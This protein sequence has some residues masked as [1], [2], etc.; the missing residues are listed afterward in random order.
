MTRRLRLPVLF[1]LL[2]LFVAS[3]APA[4]PEQGPTPVLRADFDLSEYRTVDRAITTTIQR[5]PVGSANAGQVPYVGIHFEA[6]PAN[7]LRVS[8]IDS[9]SPA[10][11]AGLQAGDIVKLV[12]GQR[13]TSVLTFREM[14]QAY[15]PGE[16]LILRVE[17]DGKAREI[18][19]TLAPLSAPLG[20]PSEGA[21]RRVRVGI[22]STPGDKG[23]RVDQVQ[24]GS[25]AEK[26]GLQPGDLIVKIDDR[27]AAGIERLTDVLADKRPGDKLKLQV[28]RDNKEVEKVVTLVAAEGGG[29][30]RGRRDWDDRRPGLFRKP[31][32]RLAVLPISYPDVKLNAKIPGAEWEKALFSTGAYTGKSVTGQTVYGS[33]NDYYRELSCGTFRVEGKVFEPLKAARKRSEYASANR[34]ALFGEV[35]D[36]LYEREGRNA[37]K[38]FDGIFFLYAGDRAPSQRGG[39]YWP[40]KANFSHKGERWNYFICPEGGERMASISV[41]SHE[42][43]HM[44]GMPDLYAAPDTPN[45]EGLGIWCTMS[46]GHGR[47]GKPLH[48]SAWCK[49][50]LGWLKPVIID[51][52]VPQKLLLAPVEGTSG[53]CYKVLIR[54]DGSEYLLLENRVAKGFDRD[55][56]G[57]GLL[58]WRVVDN[59]PILEESHGILGPDGPRRYLGSVPYPSRSNRAFTPATTPSSRPAKLGGL[60][61]Y[62]T[63]IRKL[64]DGRI[65][66]QIGYEY[67]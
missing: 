37:L 63:S 64:P 42:F 30:P 53:E 26:A 7:G 6:N 5:G 60:P 55:L 43:G 20:G 54:P 15:V 11:R 8:Q 21:P 40:H 65:A 17:R 47:D 29:G 31:A 61:V 58:I 2:A 39:L 59:R 27:I 19:V 33:M 51:P 41:I 13:A 4:A 3:S 57:E 25:P 52:T 44:L 66:F 48:F 14:V 56:P 16:K 62:I 24:P 45:T 23:I 10:A 36:Q 49:E 1:G 12:G 35:L 50:Q 46:T 34:N 9:Q 22:V 28:R 18:A 38:D 67:L 32:Y